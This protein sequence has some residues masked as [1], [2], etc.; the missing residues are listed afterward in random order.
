MSLGSRL[1]QCQ[2]TDDD[3]QIAGRNCSIVS[4][5]KSVGELLIYNITLTSMNIGGFIDND[6][7][8]EI[9]IELPLE[10]ITIYLI[11]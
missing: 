5:E 7:K 9:E 2:A 1:C 3:Q 11:C 8:I 4:R 6:V 10:F